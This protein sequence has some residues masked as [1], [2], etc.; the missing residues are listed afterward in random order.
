[1]YNTCS[2]LTHTHTYTNAC[3]FPKPSR[4][5]H[6][7]C[8]KMIASSQFHLMPINSMGVGG[9]LYS[10]MEN[11]EMMR[12]DYQKDF[13]IYLKRLHGFHTQID[14]FM[15]SLKVGIKEGVGR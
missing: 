8:V 4:E 3:I 5:M 1:M 15:E 11:I 13:E 6:E 2:V 10:F 7:D 9:V 14:Q 12:F